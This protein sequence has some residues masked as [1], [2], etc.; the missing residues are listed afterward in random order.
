M[1]PFMTG[2]EIGLLQ[3]QLYFSVTES[4]LCTWTPPSSA[5]GAPIDAGWSCESDAPQPVGLAAAAV[6]EE[7]LVCEGVIA[8][9]GPDTRIMSLCTHTL[10]LPQV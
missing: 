2:Q 1:W 3:Q 9:S 6:G 4:V 7:K 10:A 8:P 5:L